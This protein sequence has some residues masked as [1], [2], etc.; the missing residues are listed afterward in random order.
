[1]RKPF[2][3]RFVFHSSAAFRSSVASTV[4]NCCYKKYIHARLSSPPSIRIH[5]RSVPDISLSEK[6]CRRM[7]RRKL[8]RLTSG[9]SG[10]ISVAPAR[11]RAAPRRVSL[12]SHHA[13]AAET[14]I[15]ACDFLKVE[16]SRRL[17]ECTRGPPTALILHKSSSRLRISRR[18]KE[19]RRGTAEGRIYSKKAPALSWI[20]GANPQKITRE[21]RQVGQATLVE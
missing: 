1:M 7:S 13:M 21:H 9:N 20:S 10:A 16:W 8:R 4:A 6:G 19:Q 2:V 15:K 11:Q 18:A 17:S 14:E 3:R 5:F 12:I